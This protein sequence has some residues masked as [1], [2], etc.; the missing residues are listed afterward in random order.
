MLTNMALFPLKPP[1]SLRGV[2]TINLPT[3]QNPG[4]CLANAEV[5]MNAD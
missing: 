5:E 2:N 3:K 4:I 1:P